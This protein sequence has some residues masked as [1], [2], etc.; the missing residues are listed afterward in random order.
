MYFSLEMW[1]K[2]FLFKI[3]TAPEQIKFLKDNNEYRKTIRCQYRNSNVFRLFSNYTFFIHNGRTFIRVKSK[4]ITASLK[5]GQFAFT[6]KAF[7]Y[8]MRKKNKTS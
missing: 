4:R 6:R 7:Y 3:N 2:L 5:L 8:P 1:K